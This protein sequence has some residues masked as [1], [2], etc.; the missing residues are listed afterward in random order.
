MKRALTIA[1]SDSGGG[2]GIQADLKTFQR[3]EV[4]GMS[5]LTLV[6]VQNTETVSAVHLLPPDLVLAQIDAVVSDLGVDAAK[7]GALGSPEI[8]ERV[9]FAVRRHRIASLVVDPVM[10]S[11]HGSPLCGPEAAQALVKE[12]FPLA[13]LVT[14]NAHEA[15]ALLGGTV[16]SEAEARE[17]V[18]A[19]HA[20]GP[21][22]V[23]IKN[24]GTAEESVDVLFDGRELHRFATP[25][26]ETRNDHGTGCTFSAAITAL[27]ALG[28]A[29]P[30][31]VRQ[32]KAYVSKAMETAPGLGR[33]HGPVRH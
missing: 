19:L 24:V 32:A 14:P 29:L 12:L 3:F 17:A 26:L 2:A 1:G 11:K 33:G 8:V 31:A 9:A 18:R 30:E 28:V 6:T 4:F 27:L 21:K 10:V 20:L 16:A 5:A 22:A 25:R 23:V 15:K 13:A 7:T